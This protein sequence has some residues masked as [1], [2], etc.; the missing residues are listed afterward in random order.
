M[1]TPAPIQQLVAEILR[2]IRRPYPR[3]ITDRV[4]LAIENNNIFQRRYDHLW[5]VQGSYL[6]NQRIGLEVKE[7]TTGVNKGRCLH[8]QS[9]LIKSYTYH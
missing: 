4:F 7:Q 6:L 9:T 3:D 1:I 8:P 2:G 5:D